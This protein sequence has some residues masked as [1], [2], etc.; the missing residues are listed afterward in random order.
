MRV[1]DHKRFARFNYI[2]SKS[3]LYKLGDIV[4]KKR[5]DGCPIGV[6]LQ[7]HEEFEFR[8]DQFGNCCSD[9]IKLAT[10]KEI[11]KYRSDLIS[12]IYRPVAKLLTVS[13]MTRVIVDEEAT[14]EE[15]V[16][17]GRKGLLT[18]LLNDCMENVEEIR[19]DEE[20]PYGTFDT[21]NV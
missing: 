2:S 16:E 12:Q 9:E 4:I 15:I 21:D 8:T 18:S 20:C 1:K 11:Q 17:A 13:M 19:D 10:M 3:T 7:V 5:E 14:D 6:I